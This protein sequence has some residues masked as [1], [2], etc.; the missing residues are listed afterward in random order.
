VLLTTKAGGYFI[1]TGGFTE[2]LKP[3]GT[4][5]ASRDRQSGHCAKF[6]ERTLT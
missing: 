3:Y 2:A 5:Y 4:G 1:M 6:I